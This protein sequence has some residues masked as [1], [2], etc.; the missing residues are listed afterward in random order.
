VFPVFSGGLF[1]ILTL[2]WAPPANILPSEAGGSIVAGFVGSR[3]VSTRIALFLAGGYGLA[4]FVQQPGCLGTT[5]VPA[6]ARLLMGI[7]SIG[8][9]AAAKLLAGFHKTL[10]GRMRTLLERFG[11]HTLYLPSRTL[12]SGLLDEPPHNMFVIRLKPGN[13]VRTVS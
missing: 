12:L 13:K 9:G 8:T 2:R 11:V 4:A 3:P 10:A 7:G 1:E 5:C 6:K